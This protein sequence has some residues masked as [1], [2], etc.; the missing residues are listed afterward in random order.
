M[1]IA[2]SFHYFTYFSKGSCLVS[3][4]VEYNVMHGMNRI[5]TQMDMVGWYSCQFDVH[6]ILQVKDRLRKC[7][8]LKMLA[9]VDQGFNERALPDY[10]DQARWYPSLCK[11]SEKHAFLIGGHA[12]PERFLNTC[13]R[14]DM[15]ESKWEQMPAMNEPRRECSSCALAGY[16]YVFCGYNTNR[17]LQSIEKLRLVDS[18]IEQNAEAWHVI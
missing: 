3:Q 17:D 9:R 4:V 5:V 15:I 13:L 8:T 1:N 18:C 7:R 16:L 2:K 11:T 14:F 12:A 6:T 10:P